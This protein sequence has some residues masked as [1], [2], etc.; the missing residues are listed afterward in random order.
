MN[1]D[2]RITLVGLAGAMEFEICSKGDMDELTDRNFIGCTSI[3][4]NYCTLTKEWT[5]CPEFDRER[6]TVRY[7]QA[8]ADIIEK[9]A[10]ILKVP[11]SMKMHDPDMP[12]NI[13]PSNTASEK[14]VYDYTGIDFLRQKEMNY[15]E[16]RQYM[17]DAVKYNLSNT[18]DGVE[19]LNSAYDETCLPFDRDAFFGRK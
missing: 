9:K 16:W 1:W 14:L 18:P 5:A 15:L 12:E 13:W 6:L 17:C 4:A 11:Y 10:K 7:G 3:L 8:I 2:I 19:M